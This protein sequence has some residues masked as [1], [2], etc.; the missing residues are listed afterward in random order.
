MV[1]KYIIYCSIAIFAACVSFLFFYKYL[2]MSG[3]RGEVEDS[4][5][6][7]CYPPL[8]FG[9]VKIEELSKFNQTLADQFPNYQIYATFSGETCTLIM[10]IFYDYDTEFS[11]T[12]R[13]KL[14]NLVSKWTE[15][16][17]CNQTKIE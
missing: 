10:T 3:L 4:Y 13:K 14:W 16:L 2:K 8:I 7:I 17:R 5:S 12:D 15:Y 11:D 9:N 1:K 6:I